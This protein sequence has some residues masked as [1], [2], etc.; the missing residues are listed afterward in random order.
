MMSKRVKMPSKP[1]FPKITRHK[2]DEKALWESEKGYQSLVQ[3]A[4]DI[5]CTVSLD[6]TITSLNPAFENV[7]DWSCSEWI[8]KQFASL[9]HPD[10]LPLVMEEFQSS[11]QE[12][13]SG[14][15][16][17]RIVS[18]SGQYV[19]LEFKGTLLLEN[20]RATRFLAIGRDI[21]GRK[22]AEHD[23]KAGGAE[24]T[25]SRGTGRTNGRQASQ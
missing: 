13:L 7:T 17:L 15:Q 21:T 22:Q 11:L 3:N 19:T 24:P 10:D 6:G 18:K 16:E 8:G 25:N 9:V 1:P 23:L 12:E 14:V 20:E 5:I 4:L 2:R